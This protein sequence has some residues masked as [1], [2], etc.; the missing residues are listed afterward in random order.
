MK[1]A[2]TIAKN[3]KCIAECFKSLFLHFGP[4]SAFT[5]KVKGF[6]GLFVRGIN[7]TRNSHEMQKVYGKGFVFWCYFS[8]TF[9]QYPQNANYEKC[10]AAH[11]E[12]TP[13]SY[14]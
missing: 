4:G 10:I 1:Y 3:E 11:R 6:C 2:K 5:R 14:E 13:V 8:K 12:N 7:K 9:A